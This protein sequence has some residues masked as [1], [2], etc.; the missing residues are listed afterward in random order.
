MWDRI[1]YRIKE[2]MD[3]RGLSIE[4]LIFIAIAVAKNSDKRNSGKENN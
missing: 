1:K 4:L 3:F 2:I